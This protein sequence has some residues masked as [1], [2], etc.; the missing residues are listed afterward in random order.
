VALNEIFSPALKTFGRFAPIGGLFMTL[1]W[2]GI[3]LHFLTQK[4][5][6]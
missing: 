3:G 4:Y 1:G 6:K 2:V 5:S